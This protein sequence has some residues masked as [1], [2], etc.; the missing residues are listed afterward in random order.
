MD[1][2]GEGLRYGDRAGG[3]GSCGRVRDE[4]GA[5][6]GCRR[7]VLCF[8]RSLTAAERSPYCSRPLTLFPVSSSLILPQKYFEC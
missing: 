3:C 1:S 2:E 5:G 7:M 6:G 8:F 4:E